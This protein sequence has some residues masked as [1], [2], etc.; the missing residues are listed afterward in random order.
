M[1]PE[2]IAEIK[3]R[4]KWHFLTIMRERI[5]D[6]FALFADSPLWPAK[7]REHYCDDAADLMEHIDASHKDIDALIAEVERLTAENKAMRH[8]LVTTDGLYAMDKPI[9]DS[10]AFQIKHSTISGQGKRLNI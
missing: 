5:A 4:R 8:D 6:G 1:T 9:G 2:Q 3:A 10:D 7:V